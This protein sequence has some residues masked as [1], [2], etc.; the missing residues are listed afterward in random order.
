MKTYG[1]K[2]IWLK[3]PKLF[4]VRKGFIPLFISL[5]CFSEQKELLK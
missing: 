3:L 5:G 2:S 1:K 4:R